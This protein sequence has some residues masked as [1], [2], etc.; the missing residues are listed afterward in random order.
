MHIHGGEKTDGALDDSL[1]HSIT[2]LSKWHFTA[3][4]EYKRVINMLGKKDDVFNIGP[5]V[6]DQLTKIEKISKSEFETKTGFKFAEHNLLITYHPETGLEDNGITGFTNLLTVLDEIDASILFTQ[7][8]ADDGSDEILSRLI[9]FT[10]KN[11]HRCSNIASLGH[12]LYLNALHLFDAVIG[13]SSSGIIEAPLV[14]IPVLNLGNRQG[15]RLRRGEVIESSLKEA[16][17]RINLSK[18]LDHKVNSKKIPLLDKYNNSPSQAIIDFLRNR[19]E[20]TA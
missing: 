12:T 16:D 4:D 11:S 20:I 8:N 2:Q 19:F 5:M 18:L 14:G 17:I 10:E 6:L 3:A 9:Q 7:P 13:N 1:R 15:G